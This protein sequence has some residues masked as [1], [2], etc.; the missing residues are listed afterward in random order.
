VTGENFPYYPYCPYIHCIAV[1]PED[2]D[3]VIVVFPNYGVVSIYASEDG[4]NSWTPVS[5][6]L[7]ENPDGTGSGPSVRWVSIL[8]VDD[9]PLYF[10]GTGIGLF[11]TTNLDG[12]NTVWTQEG[13]STIGNVVIDMIAARQSDGIVAVG[14][15]GNGIYTA[16]ITEYPSAVEE[17]ASRPI[18][19]FALRP[20]YPNP[21][22]ETTTISFYLSHAGDVKLKVYNTLGQEVSTLVDGSLLTGE[23]QV[24]WAA[25]QLAS[26][27]YFVRLSF[28]D[29][30]QT[31]K[32]ILLK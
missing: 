8:H 20:P 16:K 18:T 13:A 32:V 17:G 23:H 26:G 6:N 7:E 29:S 24:Q 12:N 10:A 19:S 30:F 5:G 15:H 27:V 25:K 21:F 31:Q 4:G 14:T 2:V 3:K 11:S 1:D 22:N 28:K 9:K